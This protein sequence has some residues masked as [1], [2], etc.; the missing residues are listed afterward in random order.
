MQHSFNDN[1]VGKSK[2]PANELRE[3][4]ND[5]LQERQESET[6]RQNHLWLRMVKVHPSDQW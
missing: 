2:Q 1:P 4:R 5:G 3:N 6:G